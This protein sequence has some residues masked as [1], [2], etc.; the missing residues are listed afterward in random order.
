M[1]LDDTDQAID[2]RVHLERDKRIVSRGGPTNLLDSIVFDWRFHEQARNT[3]L[4]R[5][6]GP[7]IC[8]PGAAPR[9]HD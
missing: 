3:T 6:S 7:S 9:T 1:L 4:V 2:Y 5:P 8:S